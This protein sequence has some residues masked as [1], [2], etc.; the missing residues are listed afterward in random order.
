MLAARA[1]ERFV[2]AQGLR[3]GF[4]ARYEPGLDEKTRAE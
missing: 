2:W 4:F 1:T 3:P